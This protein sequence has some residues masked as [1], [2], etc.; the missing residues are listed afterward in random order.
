MNQFSRI[1]FVE[2]FPWKLRFYFQKMEN[3]Q[4]KFRQIDSFHLTSYFG[5]EIF[6]IMKM[7]QF[8]EIFIFLYIF[9]KN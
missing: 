3:I 4:N 6:E 2:Y 1:F 5:L 8:Y 9:H 7:N